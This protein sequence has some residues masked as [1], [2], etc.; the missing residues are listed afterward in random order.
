MP[1]DPNLWWRA[2]AIIA[3][4]GPLSQ[5]SA[6]LSQWRSVVQDIRADLAP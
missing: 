6:R 3:C 4:N 5:N 2:A 1:D